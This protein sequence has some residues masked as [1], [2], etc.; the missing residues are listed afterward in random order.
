MLLYVF[1]GQV[2]LACVPRPSSRDPASV[3]SALVKLLAA[4][5][6]QVWPNVRLIVRADSGF[7]RPKALRRFDKWGVHYVMGLAKNEALLHRVSLAQLALAEQQQREGGKQRLI[8]EFAYGARSWDCWR[9]VIALQLRLYTSG[10]DTPTRMSHGQ[11]RAPRQSASWVRGRFPWGTAGE[12]FRFERGKFRV[13][14][15]STREE[16]TTICPRTPLGPNVFSRILNPRK[17]AL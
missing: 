15:I 10:G 8:G 2:L 11:C 16:V 3:L 14:R 1:A 5:L 7:C 6:R 9:R 12:E 4:K 13:I 17:K